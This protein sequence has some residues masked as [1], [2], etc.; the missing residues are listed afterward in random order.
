MCSSHLPASW[1]TQVERVTTNKD[2]DLVIN[3]GLDK[4]RDIVSSVLL[5]LAQYF[6]LKVY[7]CTKLKKACYKK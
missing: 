6:R 7:T 1:G 3:W 2:Q 4:A 5:V